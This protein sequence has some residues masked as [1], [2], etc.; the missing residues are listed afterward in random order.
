M[1]RRPFSSLAPLAAALAL[2]AGASAALGQVGTAFTYQGQLRQ[3]GALVTTPTDM[4]FSLWT[5]ASGGSQVGPTVTQTG[6]AVAQGLFTASVDFGFSP[7]T[8]D[9]ALYL[10]IA[11]RNPAGSGAY[12][13]MGSR[14]RITPAPFSA[15]TRGV[16]VNGSNRVG[17]LAAPFGTNDIS[18]TLGSAG[19]A[20]PSANILF[21]NGGG[22]GNWGMAAFDGPTGY[23]DFTLS[24]SGTDFPLVIRGDSSNILLNSGGAGMVGVGTG[25]PQRSLHLKGNAVGLMLQDTADADGASARW[26][27]DTNAFGLP[28]IALVRYDSAGVAIA[29]PSSTSA[30]P[31]APPAPT[32]SAAPLR[33]ASAAPRCGSAATTTA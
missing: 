2:A 12:V 16:N 25:T 15:A 24:R 20:F 1:P 30:A 9:Q 6:V 14:Q 29:G 33:S 7:Y 32:T 26:A 21:Q 23:G 27:L 31:P 19:G 13:P 10:Q 11:V 17:I 28:G 4:Q 22:G 8:S 18:L 5:A 3:S